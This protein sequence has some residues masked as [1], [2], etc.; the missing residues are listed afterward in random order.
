MSLPSL[1]QVIDQFQL[2]A[3]KSLGQHFLLDPF[4]LARIVSLAGNLKNKKV[5]E[6]GPGPGGLTRAL[7]ETQPA[8]VVAIEQDRRC[9][10]ALR[11]LQEAYPQ[12]LTLVEGDALTLSL[13]D[14]MGK[15]PF[16][17]LS[18][19]PYNISVPL[20][21]R[22][23]QEPFSL[24]KMVLMFQKEVVDR[25]Q[26]QPG[27]KDYGRLSVMIQW[28]AEVQVGF[29]VA[30]HAFTPAPKVM[31]T[32]VLVRPYDPSEISFPH[33]PWKT[34]EALTQAAF[35]Q[36]RKMLRSSLKT[37][38]PLGLEALRLSGLPETA[39]AEE[40]P[41]QEFCRLADLWEGVKG[42]T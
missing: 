20:V 2:R 29:H 38:G 11:S 1:R 25:L 23:V 41:V 33:V 7:L 3:K 6:V 34:M 30:P 27:T 22:W 13:Q 9:L 32:V 36:R 28:R 10:E 5:L 17:L 8:Q 4:L 39:R 40:I 35:G 16:I 24:E 12:Q 42:L 26:A 19:L 14:V 21:L 31:S 37:L 15:E 18:N